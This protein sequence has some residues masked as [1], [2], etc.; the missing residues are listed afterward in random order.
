MN[1]L[2][3]LWPLSGGLLI[4]LSAGLYLLTTGRIAGISG[5]AASAAGLTGAGVSTLGLGFLSGILAGAAF[6]SAF[7]RQPEIV[8]T[9][10]APLLLAAGL[11]VGFGTRLG[12]GCTSG[13]GVCGLARL[14]KRSLAAT[15]VF[16]AV[17]ALTVFAVRLVLGGIN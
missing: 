11:L 10:S 13:H 3:I 17:A 12:S 2:T 9:A 7:I 14:S 5:L 6:A 15:S 8:V 4:G 1:N 16:M